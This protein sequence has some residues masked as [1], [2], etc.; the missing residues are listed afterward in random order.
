MRRARLWILVAYATAVA[1]A[2]AAGQ[3]APVAHPIGVA[4]WADVVATL[5]VFA[6]SLAFRNS[7]FYDPYWSLA[8]IPIALYWAQRPEL[9][10]VNPIRLVLVVALV[11]LW[12]LRLTWNWLR[13]WQGLSH[14]DWRYLDIQARTGRA[15]WLASLAGI[16]LAPTLWVF[17]GLLPVYAAVAAGREPFGYLDLA[18]AAVTLGAIWLEA[19]ADEQLKRYRDAG[20]PPTEF[21][22][23]GLWARS[24]H[25]NYCGEMGF[26]WGLWL[27][28]LAADPAWWW[29]VVGPISITLMFRFVSLP[30]IETRMQER[31]PGYTEWMKRSSMVFPRLRRAE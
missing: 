6:F 8:P 3:R 28:A 19:R 14:Q 18:A 10:G 9:V 4:L 23:S 25:P 31:R 21:L 16:H 11:L 22:R 20:P 30:M 24:R 7:S 2:V 5:A 29:T 17:L 13:G 1:V 15:Y 27:F 12:G 26:W